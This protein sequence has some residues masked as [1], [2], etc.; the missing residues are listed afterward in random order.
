MSIESHISSVAFEKTNLQALVSP[1]LYKKILCNQ[2]GV[3]GGIKVPLIKLILLKTSNVPTG[4]HPR[5][6]AKQATKDLL[7]N[8]KLKNGSIKNS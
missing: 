2:A 6:R 7:M 3:C 4:P 5:L 8:S 1:I